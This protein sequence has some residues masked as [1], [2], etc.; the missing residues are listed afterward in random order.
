MSGAA[1]AAY[2]RAKL[3]R[4]APYVGTLQP[5]VAIEIDFWVELH[6]AGD[7][8][9]NLHLQRMICRQVR[10][11]GIAEMQTRGK[12]PRVLAG[13]VVMQRGQFDLSERHTGQFPLVV[14]RQRATLQL[15]RFGSD[16]LEH[17]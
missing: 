5:S 9:K 17:R 14:W 11:D 2:A 6:C 13:T 8:L 7:D 12:H 1:R 16:L 15:I 4:L 3:A 10:I